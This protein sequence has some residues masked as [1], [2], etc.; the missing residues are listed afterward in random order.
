MR[1]CTG[2]YC[3]WLLALVLDTNSN[4]Q[5]SPPTS[6]PIHSQAIWETPDV[7]MGKQTQLYKCDTVCAVS[8]S[9]GHQWLAKARRSGCRS[10]HWTMKVVSS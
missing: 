5:H 9:E 8:G 10:V 3:R 6:R 4:K 2:E 1:L 7:A